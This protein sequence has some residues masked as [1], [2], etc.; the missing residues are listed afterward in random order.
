MQRT[1]CEVFTFDP[2]L[3]QEDLLTVA[4]V[5][6]ISFHPWGLTSENRTDAQV[7]QDGLL[8][9]VHTLPEVLQLLNHT[10]IDVLKIDI[11]GHE[12]RVLQELLSQLGESDGLPVTQLLVEL[13]F[14]PINELN[15]TTA[16][17]RDTMVALQ[18]AG[19]KTFHR[20]SNY[21]AAG[22]S[23]WEYAMMRTDGHGH[24]L[25]AKD[26]GVGLRSHSARRRSWYSAPFD[27]FWR[28]DQV[29]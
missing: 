22:Y 7:Q 28:Q 16:E 5:P 19:F 18:D 27:K 14:G 4:R 8:G 9:E 26:S 6:G 17:L 10:W 3:S 25:L 12:H 1:A 13:H 2:T 23:C 11:E 21:M 15:I 24:A 20:E 29:S